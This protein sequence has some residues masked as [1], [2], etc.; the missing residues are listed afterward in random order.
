MALGE[1]W[2]LFF[3]KQLRDGEGQSVFH[4]ACP[5]RRTFLFFWKQLCE[6]CRFS[7]PDRLGG[8]V[9]ADIRS[10]FTGQTWSSSRKPDGCLVETESGQSRLESPEVAIL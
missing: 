8:P 10:S 1:L 6:E 7:T 4:L 2:V 3:P 5:V 9:G